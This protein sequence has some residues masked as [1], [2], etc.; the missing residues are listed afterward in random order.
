MARLRNFT[1]V[2]KIVFKHIQGCTF[3]KTQII[4]SL[5]HQLSNAFKDGFSSYP[6]KDF[7]SGSLGSS[8]LSASLLLRYPKAAGYGRIWSFLTIQRNRMSI[9]QLLHFCLPFKQQTKMQITSTPDNTL[10]VI[11][12][13]LSAN[14]LHVIAPGHDSL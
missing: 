10:S 5:F 9:V 8:H 11:I 13:F 4:N 12:C 1:L 3:Q 14:N 2:A 6:L 7:Q